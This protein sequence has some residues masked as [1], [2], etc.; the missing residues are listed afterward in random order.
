MD[1]SE[2]Q[3]EVMR[4]GQLLVEH[5]LIQ[6]TWGNVSVRVDDDHFLITPSGVD[7]YRTRPED[8]VLVC[9]SDGSYEKGARPSSERRMHRAIYQV[10]PDLRAI[11]HTHSQNCAVLAGCHLDLL[12]DVLDYPCAAYAVSGSA[13]LARNVANIMRAHDG[14]IMA[15]HGFVTGAETLGR[16]LSQALEAERAAGELLGV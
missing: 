10:R 5:R 9:V 16:A 8:V 7:Y 2:L 14:C 12:T 13:G 15:N 3:R 11:V 6:A 1:V 4:Y